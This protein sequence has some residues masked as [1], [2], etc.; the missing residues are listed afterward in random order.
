[1]NKPNHYITGSFQSAAK[2]T[3]VILSFVLANLG[4]S[5][6]AFEMEKLRKERIAEYEGTWKISYNDRHGSVRV[7]TINKEGFVKWEKGSKDER[8]RLVPEG[9]GATYL[10]EFP[11]GI[12][13]RVH[14]I[15]GNN[16]RLEHF[17]T[18][19]KFKLGVM[20]ND[21]KAERLKK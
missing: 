10:I 11:S 1:M 13:E 8:G 12:V 4:F 6:S 2:L 20:N 5:Q 7:Y 3:L 16:F 14:K 18:K 21:A 15:E 9:V 17:P 19:E